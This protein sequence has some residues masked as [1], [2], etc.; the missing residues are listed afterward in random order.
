M[1]L[2][3]QTAAFIGVHSPQELRQDMGRKPG[4]S[5]RFQRERDGAHVNATAL[6][7]EAKSDDG[8]EQRVTKCRLDLWLRTGEKHENILAGHSPCLG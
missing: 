8:P 6:V 5:N 1:S 7:K 2:D 3:H 4:G